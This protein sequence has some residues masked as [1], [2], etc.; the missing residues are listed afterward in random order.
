MINRPIDT[1][2][3]SAVPPGS[4]RYYALLHTDASNHTAAVLTLISIWSNLCF[5][6]REIDAAKKQFEWWQL[7]LEKPQPDHPVTQS[8]RS[9]DPE[10]FVQ[11]LPDLKQVL[12]GYGA[13]LIE[14]SPSREQPATA[15]H[16]RTGALAATSIAGPGYAKDDKELIKRVGIALSRFR[17]IRHVHKHA[18]NG[19]LCL[20]FEPLTQA[21]LSP[22]DLIRGQYSVE[23]S[24]FLQQQ[25]SSINKQFEQYL[26]SAS[27]QPYH[28]FLYVYTAL[29]QRL[30]NNYRKHLHLLDNSDYRLTP[31]QNFW[32]AWRAQRRLVQK[33]GQT[34]PGHNRVG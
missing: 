3:Q 30:L 8:L 11:I 13:L 1:W 10:Q 29:Q 5:S 27:H 22:A 18:A 6:N 34:Q 28:Q 9:S 14:G 25:L 7:E 31:L 4:G 17:C 12:M 24:A 20:P 23:M 26:T 15:F 19:L 32:H 33:P 16:Q 21:Q 2:I